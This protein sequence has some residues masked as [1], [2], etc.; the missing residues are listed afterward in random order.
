MFFPANV[1]ATGAFLKQKKRELGLGLDLEFLQNITAPVDLEDATCGPSLR[2]G[3]G[4]VGFCPL[5]W[6]VQCVSLPLL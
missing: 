2:G 3:E 6:V 4:E 5:G 1:T